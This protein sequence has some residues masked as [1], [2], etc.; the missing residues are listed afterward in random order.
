MARATL[1]V[2]QALRNTGK[3]IEGSDDY[4]WGHMGS[5]NCG[6]LAQEV[7]RLSKKEIHARAMDGHGDWSEQLNDYCPG[8]GHRMDDLICD[9]IAFGF[10]SSDL[11]YLERLADPRV[12]ACLPQGKLTLKH[13]EKGDVVLYLNTFAQMLEDEILDKIE[14]KILPKYLLNSANSV[15]ATR[16]QLQF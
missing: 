1:Q 11:I 15:K 14:L 16:N 13:N 6:F 8:S 2:I 4:Q 10:D 12:L 3:K 5:C 7:T 9:L